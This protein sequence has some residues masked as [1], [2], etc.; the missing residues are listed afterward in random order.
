MVTQLH[1]QGAAPVLGESW[2]RKVGQES[3]EDGHSK[4][5]QPSP[6]Q[7][8]DQINSPPTTTNP[9]GGGSQPCGE[10]VGCPPDEQEKLTKSLSEGENT[11]STV[12]DNNF[13]NN[14]V[15]IIERN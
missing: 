6:P 8:R 4:E 2:E 14:E 9:E 3:G 12:D 1:S 10:E 7:P 11:I 13:E 5:P 15:T